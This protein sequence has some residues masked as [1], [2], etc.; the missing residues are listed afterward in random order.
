MT[1]GR[2][3]ATAALRAPDKLALDCDGRALTYRA[4]AGR[5]RRAGNAAAGRFRVG[6]GDRVALIAPNCLEYVELV[7]GLAERGATVATLN[8]RLTP[9]ELGPIL[10]DCDPRLVIVHPSAG[11]LAETA[12]HSGPPV[13]MLG[14]DYDALLTQAADTPPPAAPDETAPFALAYTSGT[15]GLPKGVLLTHR[16]RALTFMAMAGEYGCFGPDDHFL[17]LSPMHHGAGLVFALAPLAF[18][19][20]VSVLPAFDPQEVT[21]RLAAGD[22]G[23]VFVVPTHLR[24]LLD[25]PGDLRRHRLKAVISNAAALAQ[26]LK[27]EAIER[28]G[29][30]LLHETYGSTEAGIVTN[31]RPADLRRKPGSVGTPFAMQ[32]VELRGEDSRPVADDTPGELFV[33]GPYSFAGYRNRSAE[34]RETLVDGWVTVGD[35]AR[36]DADGF[37]TIIDRKKDMV[38]TGGINVYPREIETVIAAVPGVRDVAVVGLP[39]AEWGERLHAFVVGDA[40]AEAI[41]AACRARL[42][43][44][45]TPRGISFISELPRNAGGK[46]LKRELRSAGEDSMV[47]AIATT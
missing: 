36:R 35:M 40:S 4:L 26:P 2:G 37:L 13:L 12:R 8:T 19:G 24:R 34:T 47:E 20:R 14:P 46:V 44:F 39:D 29:D 11:E 16:S 9:A 32:E 45:K 43:G 7:I 42:A 10:D 31:I 6:P 28:L 3:L 41:V 23:G 21:D 25:L 5:M 30:G 18:G 22:I 1:L 15:T 38:V 27:E 33:R 17:A